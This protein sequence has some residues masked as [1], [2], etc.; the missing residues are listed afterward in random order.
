MRR[1]EIRRARIDALE[2]LNSLALRGNEAVSDLLVVRM[3]AF[4]L[5]AGRG[6]GG[7]ELLFHFT[8]RG[9]ALLVGR[10]A[11]VAASDELHPVFGC[12]HVTRPLRGESDRQ[13]ELRQI[14]L[15]RITPTRSVREYRPACG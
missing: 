9:P 15:A 10:Q 13:V 2:K 8:L 12:C 1:K 6:D 4:E 11:R 5:E 3:S 14:P 7:C